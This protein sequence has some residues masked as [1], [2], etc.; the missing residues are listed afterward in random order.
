M[1]FLYNLHQRLSAAAANLFYVG[2]DARRRATVQKNLYQ[3]VCCAL[4][5]SIH[6]LNSRL[7]L[8]Q[9]DLKMRCFYGSNLDTFQFLLH[10]A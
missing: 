8:S 5:I 4:L 3:C 9:Y 2:R 7:L 1:C 6:I 10:C